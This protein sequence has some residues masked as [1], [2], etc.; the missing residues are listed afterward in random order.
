MEVDKVVDTVADMVTDM[1]VDMVADMEVDKVAVIEVDMVT[2]I[3]VDMVA[4]INID[5]NTAIQFGERD[6]Q[7]SWRLV[8][9]A[10]TFSTLGLTGLRISSKL[11]E[12]IVIL[13]NHYKF[14]EKLNFFTSCIKSLL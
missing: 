4:D 7:W 5:I 6:G 1:E 13:N 12:L 3:K 9:W 10:Q 8:N 11:W 14:F 2:D